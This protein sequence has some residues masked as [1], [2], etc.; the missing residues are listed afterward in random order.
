[1]RWS[2]STEGTHSR[3]E[4]HEVSRRVIEKRCTRDLDEGRKGLR[5]FVGMTVKLLLH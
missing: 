1:M 2:E 4:E 3:E 5:I